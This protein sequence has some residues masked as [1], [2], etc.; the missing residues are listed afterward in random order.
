MPGRRYT[1]GN[2][3]RYGFN[4]KEND[5]EVKGEGN[6]QDYGM[7]IYDPRLG[8]FLSVDPLT[9]NFPWYT[10]YQFAG[11]MP[12][13]AI[14]LDGAEPLKST[15]SEILVSS[16]NTVKVTSQ[17][18]I[19]V[20]I[21][22]MSSHS[23][24]KFYMNSIKSFVENGLN[25]LQGSHSGNISSSHKFNFA[26][27]SI[28]PVEAYMQNVTYDISNVNVDIGV[29]SSINDLSSDAMIFAIVDNIKPYTE[30]GKTIDP[31]GR[32]NMKTGMTLL[33]AGELLETKVNFPMAKSLV[34]HEIGHQFYLGH[35]KDDPGSIMFTAANGIT[36]FRNDHIVAMARAAI[37]NWAYLWDKKT[38]GK[39]LTQS[40]KGS[41]N[42]SKDLETFIEE[43]K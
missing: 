8:K 40:S 37:G 27:K 22:N 7:R 9:K 39:N 36:E 21:I 15:I 6:Q 3:Y 18:Q 32:T 38:E 24:S 13:W 26:T 17:L 30:N 28:E 2:Q 25:Q 14:D 23:D 4:G 34:R 33:E 11:N 43:N 1:A 20:Q 16:N 10:P 31:I 41:D 5:N 35:D 42:P 19:K 29:V 12:I